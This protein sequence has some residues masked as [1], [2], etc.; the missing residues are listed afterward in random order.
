MIADLS[1][2]VSIGSSDCVANPAGQ[3]YEFDV[4]EDQ[5]E[6]SY[7]GDLIRHYE[8]L[9]DETKEVYLFT[10]NPNPDNLPDADIKVQHLYNVNF[11]ADMLKC[12]DLGL[13][14]VEGTQR[15][16]PHYHG[17]YQCSDDS[18][19]ELARIAHFK[20]MEKEAPSGL[21][22]TSAITIIK[23]CWYEKSNAL[24]Y[25]KKCLLD[26]M[27]CMPHNP[28]MEDSRCD[29]NWDT[30]FFFTKEKGTKRV[31]D[32]ISARYQMREFYKD[33]DY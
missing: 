5:D 25:Y 14:C 4:E 1:N 2:A 21:K 26:N 29:K 17:W 20:T 19:K 8:S 28:V 16:N 24:Y 15:G 22:I 31:A 10:W 27:L 30:A 6:I 18:R 23:D 13:V 7:R 9:I 12:C 11:L 33:S 32:K 3:N